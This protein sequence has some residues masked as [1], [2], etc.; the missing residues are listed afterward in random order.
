MTTVNVEAELK[1]ADAAKGAGDVQGA[2]FLALR[3][4]VL[5]LAHKV[6][7]TGE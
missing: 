2:I 3:L 7:T 4:L 5:L 6:T 1:K